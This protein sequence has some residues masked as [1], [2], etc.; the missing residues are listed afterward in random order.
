MFRSH[1]HR[2]TPL[3]TW[4]EGGEIEISY[5][6]G[7]SYTADY[8]TVMYH[9]EPTGAERYVE[10]CHFGSAEE[11]LRAA[12]SANDPDGWPRQVAARAAAR[13]GS[14]RS[15]VERDPNA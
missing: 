14:A 6:R 9:R 7:P 1:D 11:A 3:S 8:W 12:R 13:W 2:A 4:H 5:F 15:A 10:S